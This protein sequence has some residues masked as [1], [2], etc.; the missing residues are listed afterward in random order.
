MDVKCREREKKTILWG[1]IL[2][3]KDLGTKH[4]MPAFVQ[5]CTTFSFFLICIA[6]GLKN[7]GYLLHPILTFRLLL[8]ALN[9]HL[10]F[11]FKNTN[12]SVTL[13]NVIFIKS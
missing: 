2:N 10:K 4:V 11:I 9:V 1:Q 3:I 13:L 8:P 12:N 7:I 6:F 5:G